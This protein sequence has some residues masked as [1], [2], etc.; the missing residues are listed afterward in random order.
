MM[1]VWNLK[2]RKFLKGES[3]L[4]PGVKSKGIY[5]ILEGE[6]SVSLK[7]NFTAGIMTYNEGSFFGDTFL[8]NIDTDR[9]FT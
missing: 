7:D 3:I 4:D 9:K 2:P 6:V 5:I 8:I 1:L